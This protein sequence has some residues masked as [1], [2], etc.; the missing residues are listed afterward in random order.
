MTQIAL[1]HVETPSYVDGPG[2]RAALFLQGCSI[3]C[4]GCQNKALWNEARGTLRDVAGL[5]DELVATGLPITITGGEPF[6]QAEAL[7]QLLWQIRDR[8]PDVHVIVYSGRTFPEQVT[9]KCGM[10]ILGEI[11]VLV[12]GPYV[13]EQDSDAMQFMGSANQR[14]IDMQATLVQ[15]S[16]GE[17]MTGFVVLLNWDTPLLSI[18]DEGNLVGAVTVV[19]QFAGEG[20]LQTERRCGQA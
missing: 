20:V 5:A 6:D 2:P 16:A 13:A 3:R 4:P 14:A 15:R 19:E 17:V 18:T 11:D 8:A 10:G 7:L 1:N 9:M 12:D